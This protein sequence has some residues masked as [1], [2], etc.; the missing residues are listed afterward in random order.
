[1]TLTWNHMVHSQSDMRFKPKNL[2]YTSQHS[3]TLY[4]E[5]DANVYT[6]GDTKTH[7]LIS[8]CWQI[9]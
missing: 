2:K 4:R 7:K 3:L 5:S 8:K 9:N 6:R 1:M